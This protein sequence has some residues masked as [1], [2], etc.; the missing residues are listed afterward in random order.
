MI[1][2]LAPNQIFVF[3]SNEAGRH[4]LGAARYALHHFDAEWRVGI[5]RTGRCYAIP[6]KDRSITTLPL[7][8]IRE[9]VQQFLA[10]AKEHPELEFLV[11]EIGC[12][13][14]GYNPHQIGPMFAGATENVKLPE[15][16]GGHEP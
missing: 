9:Y 7:D 3:G 16:F 8:R 11:T 2:S 14:A 5:G 12:G 13:L 1:R 6:T 15:G 10:Y 4:G